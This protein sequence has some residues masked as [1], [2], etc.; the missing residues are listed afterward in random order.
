MTNPNRYPNIAKLPGYRQ[1]KVPSY[2]KSSLTWEFSNFLVEYA[3]KHCIEL[4]SSDSRNLS[5]FL[6]SEANDDFLIWDDLRRDCGKAMDW[7]E[8]SG[9]KVPHY[10][11]RDH[12]LSPEEVNERHILIERNIKKY[13]LY[14]VQEGKCLQCSRKL[15]FADI[16]IDH[17]QPRSKGGTYSYK[18]LQLMCPSCN[19]AKGDS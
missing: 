8:Y 6:F 7:N 3:K 14:Y 11:A 2:S 17:K 12:V 4:P 1:R 19:V 13:L 10:F 5:M 15:P 18:N 16:T 9:E